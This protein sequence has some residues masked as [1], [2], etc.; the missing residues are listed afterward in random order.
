M[1][2]GYLIFLITVGSWFYYVFFKKEKGRS[3]SLI[4]NLFK[5]LG[6]FGF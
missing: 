4:F 5:E 2:G 3:G 1:L 6:G